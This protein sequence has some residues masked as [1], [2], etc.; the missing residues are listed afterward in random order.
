MIFKGN[1]TDGGGAGRSVGYY[2]VPPSILMA[3]R[4]IL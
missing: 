2:I 3:G 1:R 4:P